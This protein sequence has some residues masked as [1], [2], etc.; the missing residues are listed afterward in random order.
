[1]RFDILD[2]VASGA[3]FSVTDNV[4]TIN[5]NEQFALLVTT[6]N[7]A[8]ELDS[9]TNGMLDSQE[10]QYFGTL[11]RNGLGDLDGDGI[12]DRVELAMGSNPTNSASRP[13]FNLQLQPEGTIVLTLQRSLISGVGYELQTSSN[14]TQWTPA[15][16]AF[17]LSSTQNLGNGF[18]RV[19]FRAM[20][21]QF[22][23]NALFVR[24]NL[25]L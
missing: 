3:A 24:L 10:L 8:T 18:E 15:M 16:E 22:P 11:T 6:Q 13:E 20:R 21:T 23:G 14:L 9:N 2:R 4:S 1:L 19:T 7:P 5:Q 12:S 25:K 17:T